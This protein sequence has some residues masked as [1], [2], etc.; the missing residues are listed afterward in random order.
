MIEL[1]K[2]LAR[3]TVLLIVVILVPAVWDASAP[4][5]RRLR[6]RT[7]LVLRSGVQPI[8]RD[9]QIWVT[10]RTM[11][12]IQLAVA[13]LE[14]GVPGMP[15]VAG[16]LTRGWCAV[17]EAVKVWCA[18]A[19]W[20][21]VVHVVKL[22][23][24]VVALFNVGTI[25]AAARYLVE[26]P[27]GSQTPAQADCLTADQADAAQ[28]CGPVLDPLA[29]LWRWGVD[30]VGWVQETAAPAVSEPGANPART[31]TVVI[32]AVLLVM[33]AKATLGAA[34][35]FRRVNDAEEN[36]RRPSV[37]QLREVRP[38]PVRGGE[39][40]RWQPVV[41]LLVVCGSVGRA[42]KRLESHHVLDAP[43]VS[44]KAAERVVSIAWRTRHGRVRRD[45]RAELKEHAAAVVGALRAM[46]AKQDNDADTRKVFEDTTAMLLTIAQ[47]YAEGRT[48]DLL[49]SKDLQGV[50][51]VVSRE[52]VRLAA[53][54]VIVTGTVAGAMA[55][56][57]PEGAATP[58]VGVISLIA[59]GVLYGGRMVGGDLVDV[60]RGQSRR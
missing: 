15:G 38:R 47:R 31:A 53:L 52:W 27:P 49:D 7:A 6:R 45:R 46:E 40:A 48:L 14:P 26:N 57:L 28:Q 8:G 22:A 10:R 34:P 18:F 23:L 21:F 59:W 5:R 1:L 54:G 43:R 29:S 33:F 36:G 16:A 37:R 44:L 9:W 32:V 3:I 55:A 60:M 20:A 58:L 13:H 11:R 35:F 25:V 39:T 4:W 17:V 24:I 56:G 51:P 12:R 50:T 41:V 19:P 2:L 42:Y 30:V